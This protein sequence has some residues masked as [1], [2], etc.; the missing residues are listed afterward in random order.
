[1]AGAVLLAGSLGL[2]GCATPAPFNPDHLQAAQ[3]SRVTGICQSVEQARPGDPAFARCVAVLSNTLRVQ[4]RTVD[5]DAASM[6]CSS[7]GLRE[8][9]A[10]MDACVAH[11]R[12]AALGPALEPPRTG[13]RRDRR[14]CAWLGVDPTSALYGECVRGLAR[15]SAQS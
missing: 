9:G 15:P 3:I 10:R 5:A 14:A 4:D 2:A 13:T 6:T 12:S 1:M 8:G 7:W 11:L